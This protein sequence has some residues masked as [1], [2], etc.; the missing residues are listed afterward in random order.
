MAKIV[1]LLYPQIVREQT[2]AFQI[3]ICK[4][5]LVG[6]AR[7][8]WANMCS[9]SFWLGEGGDPIVFA[10][11][12]SGL[13]SKR[14][15]HGKQLNHRSL[16]IS[17]LVRNESRYQFSQQQ[18]DLAPGHFRFLL[19]TPR[20][21]KSSIRIDNASAQSFDRQCLYAVVATLLGEHYK[22]YNLRMSFSSQ[23][24][25]SVSIPLET[26]G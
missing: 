4:A 9:I 1:Y 7:Y 6:L 3:P 12:V 13:I 18:P 14:Q 19:Y 24:K 20:Q 23:G 2:I 26:F 15:L 10:T 22:F 16:H 8:I 25:A 21:C 5:D 11:W 17:I